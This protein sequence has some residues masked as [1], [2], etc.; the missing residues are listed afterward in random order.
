MRGK[1]YMGNRS[2]GALRLEGNELVIMAD[3]AVADTIVSTDFNSLGLKG[4]V[5]TSPAATQ[6]NFAVNVNVSPINQEQQNVT[7]SPVPEFTTAANVNTTVVTAE[8]EERRVV[9]VAPIAQKQEPV[10]S[11]TAQPSADDVLAALLQQANEI[12]ASKPVVT[13]TAPVVNS[14]STAT[15]R[16]KGANGEVMQEIEVSSGVPT[17]QT[18]TKMPTFNTGGLN[19]DFEAYASN[20]TSTTT[21]FK[22]SSEVKADGHQN[23]NPRGKIV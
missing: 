23:N 12:E 4:V 21:G 7:I 19:F 2:T 9:P 17:Q 13:A 3:E 10:V 15:I 18:I 22:P 8:P 5:F 1:K 14:T 11:T 20:S 6:P 16:L